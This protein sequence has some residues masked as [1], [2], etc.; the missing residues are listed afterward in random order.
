MPQKTTGMTMTFPINVISQRTENQHKPD[1][2]LIMGKEQGGCSPSA[3]GGPHATD[4]CGNT[5]CAFNILCK[6]FTLL[7]PILPPGYREDL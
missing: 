4:G 1:E 5:S 2:L 3:V 6:K 7:V